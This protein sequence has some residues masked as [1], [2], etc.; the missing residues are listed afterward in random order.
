MG[1]GYARAEPA[2]TPT[3]PEAAGAGRA[4]E[5]AGAMPAPAPERAHAATEPGF[6]RYAG[7]PEMQTRRSPMTISAIRRKK[8]AASTA[9]T[10]RKS[11][12][13]SKLQRAM[14]N[15]KF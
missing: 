2:M 7:G 5:A 9:L 3:A 14:H 1:R 13:Q 15:L 8:Y 12:F 10:H 11:T 6:A 4:R